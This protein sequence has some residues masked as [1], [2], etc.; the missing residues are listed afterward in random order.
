MLL[1]RLEY[2][3]TKKARDKI[4]KEL[5]ETE[6]KQKITKTKK[7]RYL[8]YLIEL[9]NFLDKKKNICIKTMMIQIIQN[10][11]R[12]KFISTDDDYYEPLLVKSSF[13]GNYE[14]NEIRGDEDK[15]LSA[16][17]YHYMILPKLT[18]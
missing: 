18:K 8:S 2:I 5:H 3:I 1:A 9:V 13:D 16:H 6:N 14:Y 11:G 17:Q 12:W 10:K 4:R 7:E 15:K